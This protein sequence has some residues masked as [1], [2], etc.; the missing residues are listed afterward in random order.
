MYVGCGF[1]CCS[2]FF[3]WGGACPGGGGVSCTE[4]GNWELGHILPPVEHIY[5]KFCCMLFPYIF[6]PNVRK[7]EKIVKMFNPVF[8]LS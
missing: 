2:F 7:L 4:H 1:F 5:L 3:L 8:C 6:V